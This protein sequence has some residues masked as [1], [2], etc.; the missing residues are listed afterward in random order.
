MALDRSRAEIWAVAE[1][2]RSI[3][4]VS[5]RSLELAAEIE[6]GAKP[7]SVT[8]TGDGHALVSVHR[9][10]RLSVIDVVGRA[11]A[12]AIGDCHGPQGVVVAPTTGVVVVAC[13]A[14]DALLLLDGEGLSRRRRVA[15]ADGPR[16][17]P[18]R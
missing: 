14:D 10:H 4:I 12:G 18:S 7:R 11:V 2:A 6:V 3:S 8:L 17:V 13:E 5:T 1:D 9:D 15:V 16:A